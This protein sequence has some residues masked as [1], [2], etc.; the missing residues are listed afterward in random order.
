MLCWSCE[1]TRHTH[2]GAGK[3]ASK[4]KYGVEKLMTFQKVLA[5]AAGPGFECAVTGRGQLLIEYIIQA[6]EKCIKLQLV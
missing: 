3:I 2:V 5:E 1:I 6:R 4:Y